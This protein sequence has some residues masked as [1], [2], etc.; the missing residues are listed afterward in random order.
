MY[1]HIA[2]EIYKNILRHKLHRDMEVK[3]A[4]FV[5]QPNLFPLV[6]I[7]SA[8]ISDKNIPEQFGIV[9]IKSSRVKRNFDTFVLLQDSSFC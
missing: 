8:F 4:G 6:A 9:P 7:P 2:L 3:L 5:I 1:Q